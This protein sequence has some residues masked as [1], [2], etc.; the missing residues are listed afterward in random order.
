MDEPKGFRTV[1]EVRDVRIGIA[2]PQATHAFPTAARSDQAAWCWTGAN[3]QFTAYAVHAG[4]KAVFIAG[5]NHVDQAPV[6]E[7]QLP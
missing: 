6:G 1:G 4:D 5:L 2:P 3:H 7:P